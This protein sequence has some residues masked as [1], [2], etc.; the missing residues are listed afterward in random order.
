MPNYLEI[1]KHRYPNTTVCGAGRFA[2]VQLAQGR[3]Y[4]VF[5]C[6]TLDAQKAAAHFCETS[7][8]DD[9][10]VDGAE[11]LARIPDLEDADECRKRRREEAA[12]R[13]K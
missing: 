6:E 3:P 9:M 13:S 7:T 4:R 11:L 1:A 10:A 5:L 8:F 2:V 12:Q